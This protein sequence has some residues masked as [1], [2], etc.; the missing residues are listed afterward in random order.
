MVERRE[1][2]EEGEV[3][4]TVVEDVSEEDEEP[5][6]PVWPVTAPLFVENVWKD[7]RWIPAPGSFS[8]LRKGESGEDVLT[9]IATTHV[10]GSSQE[11]ETQTTSS[12]QSAQPAPTKTAG[13]SDTTRKGISNCRPHRANPGRRMGVGLQAALT[14]AFGATSASKLVKTRGMREAELTDAETVHLLSAKNYRISVALGLSP[15]ED[16]AQR[17]RIFHPLEAVLDT[18]SGLNFISKRSLSYLPESAQFLLPRD[19]P[20]L[21]GANRSKLS[22]SGVVRLKVDCGG[23][24]DDA[25]FIVVDDLPAPLILGTQWMEA[26]VSSIEVQ[27]RMLMMRDGA[28]VTI[29]GKKTGS[30]PVKLA[31]R[32]LVPAFTTVTVP[33]TCTRSGLSLMEPV[34]GK[35]KSRGVHAAAGLI[36]LPGSPGDIS[37]VEVSNFSPEDKY[38]QRGQTVATAGKPPAL[39]ALVDPSRKQESRE[40]ED[41]RD[42]VDLSHLPCEERSALREVLEKHSKMWDGTLGSVRGAIHRIDTG[43]HA[44]IHQAPRR[45]GP[46]QR[47]I[48]KNEVDRMLAEGVIRPSQSEW[49]SPVVLVAKPDGGT[50]FCV[51]YRRLNTVTRKDC[52]PLP[53]L[54][55]QIDSLG[56]AKYF[57][58]LD[59][60]CGYW[61]IPLSEQDIE[62]TAFVSH[63]GFFEFLRMPFGLCNAPATF[64]RTMDILLSGVRF[65]FA[66]IYLDDIIVYSSSFRDHLGHLDHVL[67][68]LREANVTLRLQKCRFASQ[69]V[70]YLG[71]LIRPGELALKE[72]NVKSLEGIQYPRTKTQLRSFLGTANFYRRFVRNFAKRAKPLTDLTVDEVPADLPEPTEEELDSFEDIR[73]ALLSPETLA[74][75]RSDRPFVIDTD[76]SQH[77][78]GAVLQQRDDEGKLRPI[79][80]W[81]RVLTAAEQNYSA[82]ELEAAAIVWAVQTLRHYIEGANFHVRTDHRAL[83]WIFG[84]SS[85][86][87]AR[88]ARF[89]LKLAALDFTVSYLPGKRNKV[90]DGMSRLYTSSPCDGPRSLE[91]VEEIPVLLVEDKELPVRT[92]PLISGTD[93]NAIEVTE[94]QEAQDA[95]AFCK[96]IR[97]LMG[98]N[99]TATLLYMEDDRGLLCR[100]A[101]VDRALQV[102]VPEVLRERVLCLAHYPKHAGHPGGSSLFATL[103]KDFFW[104]GMSSDCR[105]FVARCP[106]CAAQALKT[107]RRRTSYLKLF[108]P[109]GPLEFVCLDILGPLPKTS[110][111]NKFLLVIS[112]R[113]SKLTRSVPLPNARAETVAKAFFNHWLTVYGVPLVVLTDNGSNFRAKFF[114]SV[115]RLL[116]IRNLYSTAYHPQTQGQVERFNRTILSKLTHHVSENAEWDRLVFA[117]TYTYNSMVH[118]ST[119]FS[120]FELVLARTPRVP[121]LNSQQP[122]QVS[123]TRSTAETR[124]S[125]L[126]HL[127]RNATKARESLAAAQARYKRNY[128]KAVRARTEK[129]VPGMYVWVRSHADTPGS[130]KLITPVA[131]PFPVISCDENTFDI[132]TPSGNH[133]VNSDRVVR[134]P[135]PTD[136][137]ENVKYREESEGESDDGELVDASGVEEYVI[138]R[139]VGHEERGSQLFLRVRWFGYGSEDD[140]YELADDLPHEMVQRYIR[141]KKLQVRL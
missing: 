53:K 34:K 66:L 45:A 20:V 19:F 47:L 46:A 8:W 41:W 109:N 65:Q 125:F 60:N 110:A 69:E 92:G 76:A 128:D 74:L 117:H 113:F 135:S 68:T 103:R 138:D 119:G 39:V 67:K 105:A 14:T 63:A 120:P 141:K 107:A 112:D 40:V 50:R 85:S 80:F 78:L 7:G 38:L 64:Q 28:R 23:Q 2:P 30:H 72:N 4:E 57:S 33:V 17:E 106:S 22:L 93:W 25:L 16:G 115:C 10:D 101:P 136:L 70:E 102:V 27:G 5:A 118:A 97:E 104:Q 44:P 15:D 98:R 82:T 108:M 132:S 24:L 91:S 18:G 95:D 89:R 56:H 116:G 62:K 29:L 32:T 88:L 11:T 51:D 130:P 9:P 99:A 100:L 3:S 59:A 21:V 52:Y 49:A 79:G 6:R 12:V 77:Q 96:E 75:P 86:D 61:Q 31:K 139:L 111:G 83:T 122:S 126:Q 123:Q 58:T 133:R 48:E 124:E 87:N 13:D 84:P 54:D 73:G 42:E 35:S 114:Q 127:Q 131:G 81:S 37:F 134:A 94:M 140:S 1:A 55:E 71:H 121:I 129:I 90:A 137:P 26:A 43:D 36:D